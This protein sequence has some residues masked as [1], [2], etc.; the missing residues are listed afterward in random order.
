ME[1]HTLKEKYRK[2]LIQNFVPFWEN[3]IDEEYGGIFT[4][5]TNKGDKL[6][7]DTKYIWSQGRFLWLCCNL[8][9]LNDKG[10]I[11]LSPIWKEAATETYGF[12]QK[13]AVMQNN[14]I[15]FAVKRDGEKIKESEDIS[16]FA[17][18]FYIIGCN[19]YAHYTQDEK[20]FNE[21]LQ[22]YRIV[23]RRIAE[24]NFESS[25]YPIPTGYHAHSIPMILLNVSEELY[26][27]SMNFNHT[28][29]N[30]L[31]EDMNNNFNRIMD[32]QA[33]NRIMEYASV[34][35]KEAESLI[36]RHLNPGH[37]LESIWF[38]M[39]SLEHLSV[40]KEKYEK[41]L[42]LI[43]GHAFD[44][45]WDEEYGGLFRFV[46]KDGGHPKGKRLGTAVEQLITETWDTKLWWPHSEALY[47]SLLFAIK[48]KD[49]AWKERYNK[50]EEYV[51]N[52]FPNEDTELGEWIQIRDR[53]GN[54]VE[55][56]VALPV[57]DPF[58]II[59]NYILIIR[60]LEGN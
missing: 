16:I 46:D 34:N 5:Y 18:C 47:T 54:P 1:K 59:R 32:L 8:L 9:D 55:K 35:E 2:D 22:I 36:A 28:S 52:T 15:V 25:P 40:D 12:L 48:T 26:K 7:S 53:S 30:E 37:T 60:L 23:K 49:N 10:I 29:Q 27:T 6:I 50:I 14:H 21:T 20:V 43:A 58:H 31:L 41:R 33:D 24:N 44:R 39:H 17:D 42:N 4:C 56:V 57:K 13:N 3:A 38:M 45:G 19:A 51:F 11:N